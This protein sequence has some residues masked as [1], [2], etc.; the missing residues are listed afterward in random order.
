MEMEEWVEPYLQGWGQL[1]VSAG[2]S[3]SERRGLGREMGRGMVKGKEG[4]RLAVGQ[5]KERA[6]SCV[7]HGCPWRQAAGGQWEVR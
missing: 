4:Q 6:G 3:D 1:W 5:L 7:D 2:G